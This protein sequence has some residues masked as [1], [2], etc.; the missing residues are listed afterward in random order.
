MWIK[1][2]ANPLFVFLFSVLLIFFFKTGI[3]LF[4]LTPL[5]IFLPSPTLFPNQLS[6]FNYNHHTTINKINKTF[7]II[8]MS[9][10]QD[11]AAAPSKIFFYKF[12]VTPQVFYRGKYTYALVN[13]KPIVPGHVLVV[14]YRRVPRL[15]MLTVK[16]SVDFMATVQLIHAFIEKIYKADSLNIAMQDG[17]AAGQSV[18][19]V[20]CHIIPRYLKDG[21]GDHI[22]D[23]LEQ[24]EANLNGFF[25]KVCKERVI[26]ADMDRHPRPMEVMQKEATWLHE[27]LEK[28]L[29]EYKPKE[30]AD[31][32]DEIVRDD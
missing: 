16:E 20:H 24:N 14:P 21:Y 8:L 10:Q 31:P 1:I 27:E 15:K 26:A 19:H 12:P 9:T 28:F 7:T 18:P 23:L 6:S 32:E 17:I 3:I 13:L 11:M 29:K 2:E 5:Y 22:Y 4:Y 30:E 25:K